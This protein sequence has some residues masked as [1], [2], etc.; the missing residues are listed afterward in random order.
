MKIN[1]DNYEAYF[2]D[3]AE[4]KMSPEQEEVL[5]RFLQFN[6]D[7]AEELRVFTDRCF[8]RA[9]PE[10]IVYPRK[11]SLKQLVFEK[12]GAVTRDNFDMVCIAYLENDLPEKQRTLFEKYL[13]EHPSAKPHF[14]AF[15]KAFLKKEHIVYPEKGRLKHK[16]T[17]IFD[18]KMAI[19]IAAAA[20]AAIFIFVSPPFQN[21]PVE[22]TS[23]AEPKEEEALVEEAADSKE[24]AS[25]V[26][27]SNLKVIRNTT[28]PVPVSNY[29]KKDQEIRNEAE[30]NAE[31][32]KKTNEKVQFAAMDIKPVIATE[33][34]VEYDKL[35]H[36]IIPPVDINRSSLSFIDQMRYRT[37]RATEAVE[38]EE[39]LIWSLAS[40]GLKELNRIRGSETALLASKNEEGAISGIQFKSRFLNVTVPIN[41]NDD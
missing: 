30:Q 25:V 15:Q 19:P 10:T 16:R 14:T 32:G 7:L 36:E 17:R 2:L 1:R 24:P 4:G 34:T 27:P 26:A 23:I 33:I 37:M 6:P 5:H 18:W 9:T 22:I 12:I 20:A 13:S 40:N 21:L 38:E 3:F 41:R 8:S 31:N 11:E 35:S 29:K 39:A 28:T